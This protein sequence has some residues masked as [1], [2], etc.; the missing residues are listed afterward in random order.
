MA[1]SEV[2]VKP[3]TALGTSWRWYLAEFPWACR[4][5]LEG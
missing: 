3:V 2:L 5:Q 1:G 4:L